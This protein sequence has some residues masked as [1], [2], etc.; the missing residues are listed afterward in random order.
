MAQQGA[1]SPTTSGYYHPAGLMRLQNEPYFTGGVQIAFGKETMNYDTKGNPV[2]PASSNSYDADLLAPI[3]NFAV[4]KKDDDRAYFWTFGGIAG[5]GELEYK[6]GVAGIT[7]LE[8]ALRGFKLPVSDKISPLGY[9]PVVGARDKGS[10]ATGENMY[11]QTTLGMAWKVN[12]K[13]SL[14]AAGRV[15]YGWRNLE[16]NLNADVTVITDPNGKTSTLPESEYMD[17]ERTAR[18]F[19]GQYCLNLS[20]IHILR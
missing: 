1:I 9:V 10:S 15:V 20:L 7:V 4:F 12:E 18:G 6:D 2:A 8:D 13:L 19:G 14:S 5:G 17:S 16:A 3:P 11:G